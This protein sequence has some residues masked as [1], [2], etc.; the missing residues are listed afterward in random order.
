[1]NEPGDLD[2]DVAWYYAKGGERDRLDAACWLEA[3][4]TK[5]I[6]G[7]RLD[8]SRLSVVDVGAGPGVYASWLAE[9]GHEVHVVDPIP[10][11]VEQAEA[12]ARELGVSLAGAHVVGEEFTRLMTS[13]I[14]TGQWRNENRVDGLFTTAYFHRPASWR[15][16]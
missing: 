2:P 14:A 16:S 4:R 9:A 8:E 6:I 3:A 11:H 1:M 12:R 7:S 15:P 5:Q 13:A 10:L